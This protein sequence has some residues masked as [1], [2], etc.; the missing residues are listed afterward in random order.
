MNQNDVDSIVKWLGDEF[1]KRNKNVAVIGVSGG[2]DSAVV[3]SLLTR[4]DVTVYP[5]ILPARESSIDNMK[6]AER[7]INI[8][9]NTYPLPDLSALTHIRLDKEDRVRRGNVAARLRMML[10]Y[11]AAQVWH[12]L[13]VGTSNKTEIMLGYGTRW[14]D[15]VCDINPIG[16]LYKCQVYELAKL[17]DVPQ[18]II[19]AVP[20]ADLWEGQTD[21]KE[22]G[23][24][25]DEADRYFIDGP[26]HV[27]PD[28]AQK[29]LARIQAT[30]FK[31]EPIPLWSP[32]CD[33]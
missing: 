10:L 2:V 21:E 30:E 31:R 5:L 7:F 32:S 20:S 6:R 17:L 1:A 3:Y 11:D 12:G 23:F 18:E 16:N 26:Q 25:Y 14:G 27:D 15:T 28:V 22:L 13:V 19:D 8:T 24:T 29:I 4:C 33:A 9:A